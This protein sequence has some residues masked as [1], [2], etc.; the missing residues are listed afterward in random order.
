MYK[1]V[2]IIP[3]GNT[4]MFSFFAYQTLK[5]PSTTAAISRAISSAV[6]EVYGATKNQSI[7]SFS[8]CCYGKSKSVKF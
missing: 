7:R 4:R 3:V 1:D 8:W 5:I 2:L 6:A